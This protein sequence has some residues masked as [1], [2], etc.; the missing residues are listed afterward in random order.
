[1][2]GY[3]PYNSGGMGSRP[4]RDFFD[5]PPRSAGSFYSDGPSR[6]NPYG[7]SPSSFYDDE[8]R[9]RACPP[10]RPSFHRTYSP[11]PPASGNFYYDGPSRENPYGRSP[12]SFH[13]NKPR[14]RSRSPQRPSF[15]RTYSPPPPRSRGR[16]DDPPR[17]S[18]SPPRSSRYSPFSDPFT[19]PPYNSPP[20][21]PSYSSRRPPPP[22]REPTSPTPYTYSDEEPTSIPH[23]AAPWNN[24]TTSSTRSQLI[25]YFVSQGYSKPIAEAEVSREFA[26]HAPQ[27][28]AGQSGPGASRQSGRERFERWREPE[29]ERSESPPEGGR[30]YGPYGKRSPSPGAG[31]WGRS[32][33]PPRYQPSFS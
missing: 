20:P 10:Q 28:R 9:G 5:D 8:P 22:P 18:Y 7:R 6:E 15:H 11:S 25:A 13:D 14:G 33:S 21:Q 31:R 32:P 30:G 24:F 26:G 2:S 23:I 12:S 29:K 3:G 16:F 1:M 27:H 4:R 17:R 19:P